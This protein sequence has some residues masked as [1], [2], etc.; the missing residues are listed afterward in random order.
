MSRVVDVSTKLG[1]YMLKGW[2]LTDSLCPASPCRGVPLLRSPDGQQPIIRY[3]ANCDGPPKTQSSRSDGMESQSSSTVPSTSPCSRPSTPPTDISST[4][5]SPTFAP[6]VETED[7]IRRRQQSDQA[8]TEIG[9]RLLKGWAMLAEECPSI[10]C[11]GVPLV[12]PPKTGIDKEPRKECVICGTIY[13]TEDSEEWQRLVPVFAAASAPEHGLTRGSQQPGPSDRSK[14]ISQNSPQPIQLPTLDPP[15]QTPK[16]TVDLPRRASSE[17]RSTQ[18]LAAVPTASV[19]L[20]ASVHA[21]EFA[22]GTLSDRLIMT[23]TNPNLLDPSSIAA[24]AEAIGKVAHALGQVKQ[25]QHQG[26]TL[27][28]LMS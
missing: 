7:T 28:G 20:D 25:L 15:F 22:L 23:C 14:A 12:R 1:E 26:G 11:Y 9:K 8:S 2:V 27:S 5:S 10:R 21:L 16:L 18:L 24:T 6:P 4:L 3:C 13:I 19:S 17:L